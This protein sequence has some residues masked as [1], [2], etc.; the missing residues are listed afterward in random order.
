MARVRLH[1][2]SLIDVTKKYHSNIGGHVSEYKDC[3]RILSYGEA[4]WGIYQVIRLAGDNS[5]SIELSSILEIW[6]YSAMRTRSGSD[7]A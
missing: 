6:R 1:P 2:Q 4:E 7:F 5:D 3:S